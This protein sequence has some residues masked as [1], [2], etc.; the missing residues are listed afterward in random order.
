MRAKKALGQNFLRDDSVVLRIVN[1]L[2]LNANDTVVEIGPGTGALTRRLVGRARQVIAIEF[3]RDLIDGL[4]RE[5]GDSS[6]FRLI[7][8]N[9]LDVDVGRLG[10]EK[11]KVVA[12][13]PYN[14]ATPILQRLAAEREH[15][16]AMVLMFQREVVDRITAKPGTRQRGYLSVLAQNAFDLERLFDVPPTAFSPVPKVWSSVA[17]LF[18]RP[19]RDGEESFL[20]LVGGAFTHKRKTMLNNLKTMFSN[21]EAILSE[22]GIEP[23]CRAE[24]LTLDDWNSLFNTIKKAGTST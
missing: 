19:K 17:R 2:E 1:A 7:N 13:L 8:A 23:S 20:R 9:A 11:F 18:P 12:N 21:P 10:C 3:D 22:A 6:N 5:F 24:E 14:V 4:Q 16:A 15:I